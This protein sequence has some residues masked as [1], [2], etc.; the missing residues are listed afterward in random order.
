MNEAKLNK[1]EIEFLKNDHGY[2]RVIHRQ[3]GEIHAV[4]NGKTVFVGWNAEDV[5]KMRPEMRWFAN[6]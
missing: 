1:K 4:K 3:N 2:S 5:R 6:D